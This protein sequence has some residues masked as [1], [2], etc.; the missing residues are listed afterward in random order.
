MPA[1]SKSGS[2]LWV[3]LALCLLGNSLAKAEPS[4]PPG[5]NWSHLDQGRFT[6]YT[7]PGQDRLALDLAA[8]AESYRHK[9]LADLGSDGPA[10]IRVYVCDGLACMKRMAPKG[11][12]VPSWAAGMAFGHHDL[13]LLRANSQA[14]TQTLDQVFL[15]ELAHLVLIQAVGHHPVPRWFHEGFA[16]YQSG[17]WSM[18]RVTAL[19]SGVLSGRLFSLQS[20]TESFPDSPPDV[21]LAYAQ[22]IDFIGYLLNQHGRAAFHRLV[23][24]LGRGWSF[25]TAVEEAYDQ[26]IFRIEA[27]WHADLKLRFTW[28]PVLT[29]TATLW[30]L[31]TLILVAAWIRKRRTRALAFEMMEDAPDPDDEPP[32]PLSSTSP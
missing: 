14:G 5:K 12:R 3:L 18:G 22:S 8:V 4:A 16:I 2:T 24:Y 20:L 6:I 1:L 19:G 13:I 29:G 7:L 25:I 10:R 27:D 28:L 31:A 30:F 21:Q 9:V 23:D 11:A 17:E 32:P 26:S 15:H